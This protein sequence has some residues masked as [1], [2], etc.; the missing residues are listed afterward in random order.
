MQKLTEKLMTMASVLKNVHTDVYHYDALTR[1]E[2]YIVWQEET[3]AESL[4][5][6]DKHDEQTIQGTIDLYSKTEFDPLI[7]SIQE[8]LTAA[9][10]SF[11]LNLV[12][13]EDET[14]LIHYEW[15]WE[16]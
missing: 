13:Y 9:D 14:E 16:M 8:A 15:T 1:S 12:E 2:R 11:A 7:D 6:N 3:E 4:F 10:I 5:G